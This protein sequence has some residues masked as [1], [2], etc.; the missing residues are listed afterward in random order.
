M[1]GPDF[2]TDAELAPKVRRILA[3]RADN[4]VFY[5][6]EPEVPFGRAMEV[7]DLARAGGSNTIAVMT[8]PLEL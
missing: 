7:L 6:A 3:A 4:L 1:I 2:V 8:E 5:A